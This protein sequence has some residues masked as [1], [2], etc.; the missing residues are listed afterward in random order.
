[1]PKSSNSFSSLQTNQFTRKWAGTLGPTVDPYISGY[2]FT[3]WEVVP[4]ELPKFTNVPNSDLFIIDDISIKAALSASC[5]SVTIPGGTVNKADFTGLGGI[6]WSAPTNVEHDNTITCKFLETTG[7]PILTIIH[8]WVRLLRDYR[9][10]VTESSANKADYTGIMYYWTTRPDGKTIEYYASASGMFPT[11][12]PQDQYGADLSTYDKLE[13]DID[14]SI[15]YLWHEK[16]VYKNCVK[17]MIG[18]EKQK[19]MVKNEYDQIV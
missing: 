4:K 3:K 1:M 8:G 13:L 11:K 9:F 10:G 16:W 18:F 17:Y 6:K 5:L 19:E 15:D 14:F 2:F 12:D 7:L